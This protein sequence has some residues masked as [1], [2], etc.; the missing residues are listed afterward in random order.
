MKY[1]NRI[2]K[3]GIFTLVLTM[4]F[5]SCVPQ[6]KMIYLKDAEMAAANISKEYVNDR[7]VNYKLQPG[8]N[9]FIRVLNTIDERSASAISGEYT[10]RSYMSSD[11]SIYLQS[12]TLDEEG[13]IEMPLTGKIELK[14]LTIDEA[15]EKLQTE[16]AKYVNQTTLIVKLSNFNL[17]VLGEVTRPGMYKVYQSQINLFEAISMAGNM[18][19]FAKN[20]EVRIIRQTDNGSEVVTVDMGQAD[21]LSSPYYYLKPNDIIYVEPLKIKQWGF[22][23]F[24]YSTV[25]SV[26]SLGVTLVTLV[27]SMNK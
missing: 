23:A 27:R 7:S 12:Y 17:T 19:N 15:K 8:D 20:S 16:L 9:L 2:T 1:F 4:M 22:T 5:A 13:C 25:I 26:I 14:N 10:N 24:P 3:L 11:A 6:K 21:I 18:T